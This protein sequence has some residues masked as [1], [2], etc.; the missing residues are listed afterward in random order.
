LQH[1]LVS[2][3]P[4]VA[5]RQ[6]KNLINPWGNGFGASP[7]W[8]GDNRT[9]LA[10][11]YDGT[12]AV[13]SL[14]V[15]IPSPTGATGGRVTGVILNAFSSNTAAFN[16]APGKPPNFIFCTEDGVIA[17][18]NPTADATHALV[19][20]DNSKSGALYTGCALGGT[21]AAPL[22]FAANF[23][24]GTVDVLDA[25]LNLNPG[26]FAHAFVNASIPAGFAP[27]NVHNLSGQLYVEYAKQDASKKLS[28]FG[29]GNGYVAVFDFNAN[30]V[31]NLIMQGP[32]N[33][34]WGV[35]LAPASFGPFGG[36]LL[37]GNLGDGTINAFDQATGNPLG[38]LNDAA[39]KPISIQGLWEIAFGSGARNEDPGTLYFTSGPGTLGTATD[40]LYSHGLLGSIQAV[41]FFTSTNVL[42]SGSNLNTPIAPNT[43]VTIKGNGLSSVTATW[44]VTG[45]T[46]PTTT[47]GVSVSING[48]AAPVSFVSNTQ[49]N[50]LVPADIQGGTTAQ[51]KVINNGLTSAAVNASVAFIAPS[52]FTLSPAASNGNLYVAATHANGQI[53]APAGLLGANVTTSPAVPGET[54]ALYGTGFGSAGN[55]A[56]GSPFGGFPLPLPVTPTIVID[57]FVA[58]VLFA[59]LIGPGLYQFNVTLPTAFIGPVRGPDALVVA[60]LGD[61]ITQPNAFIRVS[62]GGTP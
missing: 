37:I 61:E 23:S 24:A 35:A 18:W 34:P 16:V 46:L 13:Q 40:P 45:T 27:H 57:G 20:L 9:G 62:T 25:G 44:N 28:V 21:A 33:A 42:N 51:I 60:F 12:G 32:L 15:S 11:L 48:E 29:V 6:D 49:V 52:F 30:L 50:F 54:I 17:G 41:P 7:F 14:V 59:G 47:G 26:N 31:K 53:V 58:N 39:G 1:N 19:M 5:D 22:I 55:I 56:A 43:W 10:T 3:L 4:N 36:S 38:T 2:D 8:V